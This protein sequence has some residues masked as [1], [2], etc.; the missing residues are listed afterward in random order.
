MGNT[1]E[2]HIKT[3]QASCLEC[4]EVAM[5]IGYERGSVE[6]RRRA[7]FVKEV[8]E[9]ERMVLDGLCCENLANYLVREE[10]LRSFDHGKK[11]RSFLTTAGV[12]SVNIL[13]QKGRLTR[14]V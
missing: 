5:V 14:I 13:R 4:G 11:V 3:D 7:T 12:R 2:E 1:L 9:L 10:L 8:S 6:N